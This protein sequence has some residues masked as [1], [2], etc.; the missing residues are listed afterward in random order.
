MWELFVETR[1]WQLRSMVVGVGDGF[2]PFWPPGPSSPS[3][4]SYGASPCFS[5]PTPLQL[6]CPSPVSLYPLYRILTGLE[7]ERSPPS[8]VPVPLLSLLLELHFPPLAL[9]AHLHPGFF[10]L[11]SPASVP[12]PAVADP[13]SHPNLQAAGLAGQALAKAVNRSAA[14]LCR[15]VCVLYFYVFDRS[16]SQKKK[17]KKKDKETPPHAPPHPFK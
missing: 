10:L 11:S 13:L 8:S 14:L 7:G 4:E 16:H 17:K 1:C 6:C 2:V 9:S 12:L 5:V 3:P 15:F